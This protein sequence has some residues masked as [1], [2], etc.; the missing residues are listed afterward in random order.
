M[1][2]SLAALI[3]CDLGN[4]VHRTV[5]LW[6]HTWD[7]DRCVGAGSGMG[8]GNWPLLIHVGYHVTR[9]KASQNVNVGMRYVCTW[10]RVAG[11]VG[12]EEKHAHCC[13]AYQLYFFTCDM[14][15]S[16]LR[17]I[18][19]LVLSSLKMKGI[20]SFLVWYLAYFP[21]VGIYSICHMS[22]TIRCII[23]LDGK[24]RVIVLFHVFSWNVQNMI[25]S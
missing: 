21:L 15:K 17:H 16:S 1:H 10:G 6:R 24:S 20:L 23:I 3:S 11:W 12:K 18:H 2:T 22:Q 8:G 9:F 19:D 7:I 5:T 4:L 13:Y 14:Y 25:P